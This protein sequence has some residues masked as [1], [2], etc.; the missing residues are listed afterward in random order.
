MCDSVN[1]YLHSYLVFIVLNAMCMTILNLLIRNTTHT[2][3]RSVSSI[4]RKYQ[5]PCDYIDKGPKQ[6]NKGTG[7]PH[8]LPS[9]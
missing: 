6:E 9:K 2:S 7:N 4:E 3:Q 1:E 8:L 5:K